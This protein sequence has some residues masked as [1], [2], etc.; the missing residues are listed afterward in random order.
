MKSLPMMQSS[1]NLTPSRA[2]LS[3]SMSM[4]SFGRRNSGIPYFSTPP[5]TCRASYTVT[6]TPALT[7][8]P[9]QA[10]LAGPEPTTAA[11]FPVFTNCG[12]LSHPRPAAKSA[13]KRSRRPMAT[14]SSLLP[15]MQVASHCTSCGQTRPQTA[16]SALESFRIR[17][18]SG[19]S[20]RARAPMNPGMSISTGQP[21][22]HLG[23]LHCR[24]RSASRNAISR[25][26]PRA[27]SSKLPARTLGSC[28]GIA[29]RVGAIVLMFLGTLAA[30]ASAGTG[31]GGGPSI[32]GRLRDAGT[33]GLAPPA[34]S[35]SSFRRSSS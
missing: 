11:R 16:G 2:R 12:G 33:A 7:R 24:Q 20:L 26:Y 8:S 17:Y 6:S 34:P 19:I 23:F 21:G 9:A 25:V 28:S 18:D 15:M 3:I 14:G 5:A 10:R 32:A 35:V 4:M 29:V 22:T 27:T 31:A 1:S 30:A 13:T